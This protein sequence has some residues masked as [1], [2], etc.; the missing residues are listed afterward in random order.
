VALATLSVHAHF[1]FDRWNGEVAGSIHLQSPLAPLGDIDH[2][3]V[4]RRQFIDGGEQPRGSTPN[5]VSF[6]RRVCALTCKLNIGRHP[7]LPNVVPQNLAG[8]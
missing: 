5:G 6:N 3:R 1:Q 7:G 2:F 4:F 8:T